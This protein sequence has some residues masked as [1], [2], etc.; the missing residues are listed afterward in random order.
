MVEMPARAPYH[1]VPPQRVHQREPAGTSQDSRCDF[2]V[3]NT[4]PS[5]TCVCATTPYNPVTGTCTRADVTTFTL[6]AR[7]APTA[8]TRSIFPVTFMAAGACA[9]DGPVDNRSLL[10][11]GASRGCRSRLPESLPTLRSRRRSRWSSSSRCASPGPAAPAPPSSA[12]GPFQLIKAFDAATSGI[13]RAPAV[14]PFR[15]VLPGL[16]AGIHPP[17]LRRGQHRPAPR[18]RPDMADSRWQ[19][20]RAGGRHHRLELHSAWRLPGSPAI[21]FGGFQM[22][23][24]LLLFDM[25]K[26]TFGF[27]GPL[28]GI[29]TGCHNFS[30]T[31][32]PPC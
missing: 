27:S 9:S 14:K 6:S 8:R 12:G 18:R 24:R 4:D 32:T 17:R 28:A 19:L 31:M 11:A 23:D 3:D 7:T 25:Y 21:L 2:A 22:E 29:R 10:T 15:D 30:L 16:R 1:P 5:P 20:A 26:E 13:P